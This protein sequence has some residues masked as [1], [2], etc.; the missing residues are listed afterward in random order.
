MMGYLMERD[1]AL[2]RLMENYAQRQG[3][4]P[5]AYKFI[6]AGSRLV[7]TLTPNSLMEGCGYMPMEDDAIIDA[8]L[9]QVGD[10]GRFGAHAGS[11]QPGYIFTCT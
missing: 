7:D 8:M 3:G 10:I 9:E 4:A 2:R 1:S 5:T 11:L 6:F